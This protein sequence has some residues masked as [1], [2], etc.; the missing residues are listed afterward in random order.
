[1]NLAP[2]IVVA[3]GLTDP[4]RDGIAAAS[5][6]EVSQT[7][8][9]RSADRRVLQ[10]YLEP[11]SPYLAD[12]A[13]TEVIVNHPG[14]VFTEGP[15]GWTRHAVPALSDAHLRNLALAAAAFTRQDVTPEHPIVSTVLP[16]GE[17]CQIVAPPAVPAGTVSLTIRKVARLA[18]TLDEFERRDLFRDVRVATRALSPE[19]DDLVRLRDAGAWRA[20]LERAVRARRNIVI[21]GATG[22]GKTTLAKGLVACIPEHERLLT[23][24]DTPE[25][26]IPHANHVRLLYAKDGQGLSRIGPRELL[27]SSLRMRPD[28]ILM[29]EVGS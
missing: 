13:L 15:A 5:A 6:G 25:L 24:E 17:R 22:S 21:S 12:A 19:E 8:E 11:L 3:P 7:I 28:R 9:R 16:D 14:A 23:I 10:R 4:M 2:P 18:V 26:I 1:M 29:Q 20:F 27:E